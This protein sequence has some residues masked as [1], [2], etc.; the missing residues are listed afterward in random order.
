M[1]EHELTLVIRARDM[2]SR[3]ITSATSGIKSFFAS[4]TSGA[5]AGA[6]F[7]AVAGT[8]VGTM[9]LLASAARTLVGDWEASARAYGKMTAILQQT[10]YAA[11]ITS[12]EAAELA[13]SLQ[14]T[15]GASDEATASVIALLAAQKTIKGDNL[16]RAAE[17]AIDLAEGMRRAG[18]ESG[19]M[20]EMS[21]SL[22]LALADPERGM[23]RLTRM[24]IMLT[25]SQTKMA[26]EFA[27][28]GETAKAQTVILDAL[29]ASY[30]GA[31]AAANK[32]TG[33]LAT[34]RETIGDLRE[35]L[36][37]A[38]A[39]S[40]TFKSA[41]EA[42]QEAT[43]RLLASGAIELWAER[44]KR[45]LES[46][47]PAAE[48]AMAALKGVLSLTAQGGGFLG[49]LM[50]GQSIGEAWAGRK[51][52]AAAA[53]VSEQQAL[54]DIRARI[55]AE[56]AA[57]DEAERKQAAAAAETERKARIGAIGAI[58]GADSLDVSALQGSVDEAVAKVQAKDITAKIVAKLDLDSAQTAQSLVESVQSQLD[59]L[60]SDAYDRRTAALQEE[61]AALE[62][63][64]GLRAQSTALETN[65]FSAREAALTT[66]RENLQSE[67]QKAYETRPTAATIGAAANLAQSADILKLAELSLY[68]RGIS[69]PT[70]SG[71]WGSNSR[72]ETY[73]ELRQREAEKMA[74]QMVLEQPDL[75]KSQAGKLQAERDAA[76]G[77]Y[78]ASADAKRAEMLAF[79]ATLNADKASVEAERKR[80]ADAT[81]DAE[82]RATRAKRAAEDAGAEMAALIAAGERVDK[83][84]AEKVREQIEQAIAEQA[85]AEKIADIDRRLVGITAQPDYMVPTVAPTRSEQARRYMDRANADAAIERQNQKDA[86]RQADLER[87]LA[88][89]RHITK[90]GEDW[91][92]ARWNL[93]NA[94]AKEKAKADEEKTLLKQRDELAKD[95]WKD[96]KEIRDLL[97]KNLQ[98]S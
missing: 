43:Q 20:E 76:Y 73:N 95:G 24:G 6:A 11:G 90:K 62:Q 50:G 83:G 88:E 80:L 40:A 5:A 96:V 98:A 49:G 51:D 1:A 25:D 54:E 65:D 66:M 60:Y 34:L 38:I 19:N 10:G 92:K 47:A 56:N 63:L 3:V 48:L 93:S 7:G 9:R 71:L 75:L 78:T 15:T 39:H 69:K 52:A 85:N 70:A 31:A 28:N 55:A 12:R 2:F 42:M 37:T 53:K 94:E 21:R 13:A 44:A 8:V 46:L 35:A 23:S 74:A 26:K 84:A 36:G 72:I 4:L 58:L 59:T 86:K 33:G 64:G 79:E 45:G 61:Q 30:G 29:E 32:A 87:R 27:R 91:L 77:R 82:A 22:G 16:K 14:R 89:D 17:L 18:Q 41:V 68:D 81:A 67:L 57:Q 97:E